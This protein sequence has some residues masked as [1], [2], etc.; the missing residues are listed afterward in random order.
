MPEAV[1]M[2]LLWDERQPSVVVDFHHQGSYVDD[3]GRLIT[4]SIMWPNATEEA[5]RLGIADEFAETITMSKRAV[6]IML[7][8][9]EQYGYANITRYP[10]T[11]TGI[12]RN[13]YGLLGSTSVLFEVRGGI[14]AKS[15][16]YLAKHAEVSGMAV[17][18]SAA[19]GSLWTASTAPADNIRER[20][21]SVDNPHGPPEGARGGCVTA[22][23]GQ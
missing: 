22:P 15:N 3:D 4:G 8:S 9:L 17:L 2:R 12:A 11:S 1:A 6:S 16:G 10:S 19:D 20:G 5:E 13:A 7:T 23:K 18:S 14:G 21:E